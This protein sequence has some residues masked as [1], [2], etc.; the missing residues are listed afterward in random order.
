MYTPRVLGAVAGQD[1]EILNADKTMHNVHTYKGQETVL[2]A[3]QPAGAQA[4]KR[5][6][7]DEAGIVKVK[8]DVHPWMTAYIVVTDH[9]YFA[10]TDDSGAFKIANV[11]PGKYKVEA[12]HPEFGTMTKEVEVVSNK[13]I[14]PA[15]SYTG[16]EKKP[17]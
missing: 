5:P 2:N 16:T 14:D 1:V 9:P 8:C 4:L 10:V 17:E 13:P 3:G 7:S 11:P 6:A 15:F 12:W